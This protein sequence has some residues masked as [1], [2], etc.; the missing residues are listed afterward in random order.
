MKKLQLIAFVLLLVLS[1]CTKKEGLTYENFIGRWDI[2]ALYLNGG[3]T[4]MLAMAGLF[5][6]CLKSKST[7]EFTER[8]TFE[9]QT[10]CDWMA[11]SGTYS[12]MGE[13]GE[14]LEAVGE[15]GTQYFTFSN[16]QFQMILETGDYRLGDGF[17]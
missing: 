16:G 9:L 17:A 1:G 8:M 2:T 3:S 5:E 4:N 13:N 15:Q 6:P 14:T 11:D 12:L 10:P 7:L